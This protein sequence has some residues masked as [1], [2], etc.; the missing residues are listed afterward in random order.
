[1]TLKT[2]GAS[3]VVGVETSKGKGTE[4]LGYRSFFKEAW[5]LGKERGLYQGEGAGVLG[6]QRIF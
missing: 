6:G 1:M 5:L 4:D 2:K 3:R